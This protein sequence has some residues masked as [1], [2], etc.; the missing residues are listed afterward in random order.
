MQMQNKLSKKLNKFW[1]QFRVLWNTKSIDRLLKEAGVDVSPEYGVSGEINS[2]EEDIVLARLY[3][4]KLFM[5]LIKKYAER[6]T[7]D[8]ISKAI[9]NEQFWKLR[10]QFFCYNS[11][12][13]KSKRAYLRLQSKAK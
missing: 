11:L 5:A 9:M 3:Q 13:V 7:K 4:D 1:Y 8:M 6:A 10:G 12:L 2:I